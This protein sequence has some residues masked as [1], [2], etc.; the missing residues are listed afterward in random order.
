MKFNGKITNLRILRQGEDPGEESD[1][2]E[3]QDEPIEKAKDLSGKLSTKEL[4][5][6]FGIPYKNETKKYEG[7]TTLMFSGARTK[8]QLGISVEAEVNHFFDDSSKK[9]RKRPTFTI[10]MVVFVLEKPN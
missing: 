3:D 2:V 9:T 6:A 7:Q 8:E 5:K 4:C 10:L 1:Q